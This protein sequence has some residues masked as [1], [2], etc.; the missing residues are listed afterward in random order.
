M[1]VF[2]SVGFSQ[3]SESRKCPNARHHP[4]PRST[5]MRDFVAG[6]RVQTVVRW[7]AYISTLL[8]SATPRSNHES[9]TDNHQQWRKPRHTQI[10]HPVKI[11]DSRH[12]CANEKKNSEY[13]EN[14]WIQSFT[15]DRDLTRAA[16]F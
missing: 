11:K 16:Y 12:D 15:S 6:R 5:C 8:S 4:R 14:I 9:R 1:Q 3:P 10:S 2:F 7:R 13:A